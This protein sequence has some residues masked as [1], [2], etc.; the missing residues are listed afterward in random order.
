M[1]RETITFNFENEEQQR[2]FHKRLASSNA[3]VLAE[4]EACARLADLQAALDRRKAETLRDVDNSFDDCAITADSI[5]RAI[6]FRT[7]LEKD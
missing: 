4:R 7:E 6:R 3:D 2:R 1:I 5:A